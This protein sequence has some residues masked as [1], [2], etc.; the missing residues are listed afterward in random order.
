M[1]IYEY[2]CTACG[3]HIDVIHAI[4]GQ[5]P[6]VCEVCGGAMKKELTAPA[7]HFK[8]S[9]WAK[10]DARVAATPAPASDAAKPD[11]APGPGSTDP[12]TPGATPAPAVPAAPA[13]PAAA[14]TTTPAAAPAANTTGG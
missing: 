12:A 11:A 6:T 9:G 2:A 13:A 1:P 10:K 5:G 8:G 3:R 7:I 14:T 4:S